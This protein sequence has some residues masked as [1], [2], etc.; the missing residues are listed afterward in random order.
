MKRDHYQTEG[1]TKFPGLTDRAWDRIM[2]VARKKA[3]LPEHAKRGPKK[4][5]KK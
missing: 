2:P 4:Q 1:M 3:G 5:T